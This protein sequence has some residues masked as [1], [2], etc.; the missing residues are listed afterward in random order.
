MS[1]PTTS[2]AFTVGKINDVWTQQITDVSVD[3]LGE[4]DVLIAVEYS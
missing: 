4:G 3:D 2:R 1:N